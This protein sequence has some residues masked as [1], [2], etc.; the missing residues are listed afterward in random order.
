[1][2]QRRTSRRTSLA[3]LQSKLRG[4]WK[5]NGPCDGNLVLEAGGTYQRQHFSPGNNSL[6]GTWTVR[7]DALPPTLVLVCATADDPDYVGKTTE[8]K[9]LQLNDA[10]LT[11]QYS[12]QTPAR[13]TRLKK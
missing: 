1:M 7:W 9:L 3:A 11:Y 2:V 10:S 8:V 13:Y 6:S 5:G 4:A 12:G